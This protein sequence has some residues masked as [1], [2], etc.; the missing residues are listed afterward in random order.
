M[1]RIVLLWVIIVCSRPERLCAI[2][3][4]GGGSTLIIVRCVTKDCG[5]LHI[6]SARLTKMLSPSE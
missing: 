6:N 2:M 5:T 1:S 3:G 4:W